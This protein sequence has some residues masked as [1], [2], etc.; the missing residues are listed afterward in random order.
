MYG[1]KWSHMGT[2]YGFKSYMIWTK[3]Y[4]IWTK[5]HM[6]WFQSY[7]IWTYHIWFD[8]WLQVGLVYD[9]YQYHIWYHIW[10]SSMIIYGPYMIIYG[11]YM[12]WK[13]CPYMI[14]NPYMI[15]IYDLDDIWSHIWEGLPLGCILMKKLISNVK[16]NINHQELSC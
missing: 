15:P 13:R 16:F 10:L 14:W 3:P 6:I 9:L 2:I 12:I 1:F 8:I 4:M 11:P 7:M 5:A